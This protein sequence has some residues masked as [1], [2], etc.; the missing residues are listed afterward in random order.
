MSAPVHPGF[1]DAHQ[2][3][4]VPRISTRTEAQTEGRRCV[5]CSGPASVDLG[6]RLSARDGILERWEPRACLSCTR[7]EAGR[8][9]DVHV[10]ACARCAPALYCPDARALHSL[11]QRAPR[12]R[13]TG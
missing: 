5:W 4:A 9:Y 3:L 6:P 12:M 8:V 11:S 1:V 13:Q 2:M 10:G 7:R